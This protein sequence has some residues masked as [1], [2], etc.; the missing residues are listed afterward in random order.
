[1]T[2]F[3]DRYI[4]PLQDIEA[5]ETGAALED[6]SS[7]VLGKILGHL[8]KEQPSMPFTLKEL[9]KNGDVVQDITEV[10]LENEAIGSS[11]CKEILKTELHYFHAK[12]KTFREKEEKH[13]SLGT[14][15]HMAFLEPSRFENLLTEPPCSMASFKGMKE[16]ME[17]YIDLYQYD[18]RFSEVKHVWTNYKFPSLDENLPLLKKILEDFRLNSPLQTVD[19]KSKSII[20]AL[21]VNYYAYGDGILPLL[22]RHAMKETSFYTVDKATGLKVKVRPDGL[23]LEKNIGVNAVISFKTT[24]ADSVRQFE[25]DTAKF[26][27]ELTEGMYQ[28]VI[29]DITGKAFDVTI[30][31][32][33]QVVPPY[34]PALFIWDNQDI[35]NGKE[36]YHKALSMI[37]SIKDKKHLSGFDAM[38]DE[39]Q[40][41]I[42]V[43]KQPDWAKE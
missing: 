11:L 27:Y 37:K 31:V 17:F 18:Q 22:L 40:R 4:Q 12:N 34:L 23:Q 38:A 29:S 19:A 32:M 6:S 3:D 43:L 9:A 24:S 35:L 10:Y 5:A 28:E 16:V 42:I 7:K 14:F 26:K 41:G 39:D 36:K 13:F 2:N 15:A 8:L 21:K 30:L 25:N 20:D 1:M 33:L